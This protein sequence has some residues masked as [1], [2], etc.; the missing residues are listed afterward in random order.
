MVKFLPISH[1]LKERLRP[2]SILYWLRF[3]TRWPM[4]RNSPVTRPHCLPHQIKICRQFHHQNICH[5]FGKS[6]FHFHIKTILITLRLKVG[7]DFEDKSRQD[8]EDFEAEV[9]S[10]FWN[11]SLF[12]ILKKKFGRDFW[13]WS[14]IEMLKLKFGQDFYHA[15]LTSALKSISP[16]NFA[17]GYRVLCLGKDDF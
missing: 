13:S 10:R 3:L 6:H 5:R 16:L 12:N 7:W 9:W 15:S 2:H 4:S 11:L 14:L 1:Y 8:F 17:H